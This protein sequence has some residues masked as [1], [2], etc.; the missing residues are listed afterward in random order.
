MYYPEQWVPSHA[1]QWLQQGTAGITPPHTPCGTLGSTNTGENSRALLWYRG[2]QYSHIPRKILSFGFQVWGFSLRLTGPEKAAAG[3][4]LPPQL[5]ATRNR[6]WDC[7]S[8]EWWQSRSSREQQGTAL[9][10]P[11]SL[12]ITGRD[13]GRE[14]AREWWLGDL[15]GVN[16]A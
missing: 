6:L 13:A 9:V 8:I 15:P 1:S 11:L 14:A 10:Q 16:K 5:V 7:S 4:C 12:C 2:Y 3:L